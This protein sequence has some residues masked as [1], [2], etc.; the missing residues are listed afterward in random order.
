M[1]LCTAFHLFGIAYWCPIVAC[2]GNSYVTGPFTIVYDPTSLPVLSVLQSGKEI[3]STVTSGDSY[4]AAASVQQ[5]VSQNGGVFVVTSKTV[6]T[7]AGA[8]IT[9]GWSGPRT[10]DT[11]YPRVTFTGQLC[12]EEPFELWFEAVDASDGNETATHLQFGASLTEASE[13]NQLLLT[14]PS[15]K[16]EHFYGFGNQYTLLDMKGQRLPVFLTEQGVG[17]G[18][19]PLTLIL[20]LKSPGAGM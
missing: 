8:N 13:Y 12:G 19:Q 6:K 16:D 2:V 15:E 11:A 10:P 14:Y 7:C 18:L 3:W 9:R 20:D 5:N 4:L 17:R 1:Q